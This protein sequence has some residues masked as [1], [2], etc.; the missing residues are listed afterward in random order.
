MILRLIP[1]SESLLHP[2]QEDCCDAAF[3]V[4]EPRDEP[5]LTR[6]GLIEVNLD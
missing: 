3:F 4:T 5:T 6:H 2:S 1:D